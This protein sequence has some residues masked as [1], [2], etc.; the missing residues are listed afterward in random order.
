MAPWRSPLWANTQVCPPQRLE[1]QVRQL[2]CQLR[3]IQGHQHPHSQVHLLLEYQVRQ[4]DF[5]SP[6][7]QVHQRQEYQEHQHVLIA[8]QQQGAQ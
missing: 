1:Y 4:L 2:D 6:H 5:P 3:Q 8:H 7:S